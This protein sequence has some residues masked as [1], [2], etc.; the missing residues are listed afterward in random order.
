MNSRTISFG[1]GAVEV[2]SADPAC[3]RIVNFLF[4]LTQQDPN[5]SPHLRFDLEQD[6]NGQIEIICSDPN[7]NRLASASQATLYLMDRVCYHLADRAS[8]GAILHAAMLSLDGKALIFPGASGSGK[9]TLAVWLARQG[10]VYAS[11]EL[12]HIPRLTVSA[13]GFTRP[14]HIKSTAAAL[15][16]LPGGEA[17]LRLESFGDLPP[18]F[19]LHPRAVNTQMTTGMLCIQAI[20]FPHFEAQADYALQPLSKAETTLRLAGCLINARNLPDHGFPE[21]IRLSR[22]LPGYTLTY[23]NF[24]QIGDSLHRLC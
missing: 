24:E 15:F 1:G 4:D 2:G 21:M 10:F 6:E 20:V 22:S 8:T 5:A 17:I 13:Q 19:L 23:G 12:V 14:L 9:S 11:D 18:A 3:N 16:P 7:E